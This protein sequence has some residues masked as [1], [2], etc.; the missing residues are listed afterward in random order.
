MSTDT[1]SA[2]V[3]RFDRIWTQARRVQLWQS[4]CWGVLTALGGIAL[5]AA[6]DYLLELPHLLRIVAIGAI[7]VASIAVVTMLSVQSV[8]RWRRTATAAAIEQ[9]F[10]QLGQRIRTTVQYGPLSSEQRSEAGVATNLVTALEDDTVRRAQPLPL[11][12]VIPWKSLAVASLL[13]AVVG[14]G[15]AG[16]SALN[17]EWRAAAQRAFLGDEP[18]T[19]ITVTPGNLTVKEG[20][21]A[22]VEVV[23]EG[24][25]GKQISFLTRQLDEEG[26]EWE[27]ELLAAADAEPAGERALKFSVPQPDAQ[28]CSGIPLAYQP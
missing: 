20:E 17:W 28:F 16:A 1:R 24:R 4:L 26:S 25:T 7:S 27:P 21:S 10:P 15:L 9:V 2:F 14:L 3:T 8:R 11:D 19:K 23:I 18:Y 12:A 22:S 13:A 6:V 5:L